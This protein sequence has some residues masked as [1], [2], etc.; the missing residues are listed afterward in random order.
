MVDQAVNSRSYQ[1]LN[2]TVRQVV[3]QAVGTGNKT[4][5]KILDSN[6]QQNRKK[7]YAN[8][9]GKMAKAV[10]QYLSGIPLAMFAFLALLGGTISEEPITNYPG[11][12][13]FLLIILA[14]GI[15]LIRSG[16][17]TVKTVKRFK[18]YKRMLG[19][20][21]YC[22][23]DDLARSVGKNKAFVQKDLRRM[24]NKGFFPEGHLDKE[25]NTLIISHETF[26]YY[27][28]S[29]RQWEKVKQQEAAAQAQKAPDSSDPR[30][31]RCW[32]G[33]AHLS[34]RSANAMTIS[35]GR[36]YLKRYPA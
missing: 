10:F 16:V 30:Y 33:E 20:K 28:Q 3:A 9:I 14:I 21:T 8:T 23:V 7:L 1:Q 22:S 25:A 18:V 15:W 4:A 27:E 26:H 5:Q 17:Y 32:I 12:V 24:I 11:V 19:Q 13:A 34:P 36:R 2:Q 31:R 29:G 35:P 6:G